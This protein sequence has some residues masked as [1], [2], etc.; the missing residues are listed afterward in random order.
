LRY[1]DSSALVPL[2]SK[3]AATEKMT[4]LYRADAAIATWWSSR[5]ECES[6]IAR[7]MR[8]GAIAEPEIAIA[9]GKL[10][11]L[12]REWEEVAPSEEL[13]EAARRLVR[14]RKLSAADALQLAAALVA[15]GGSPPQLDFVCLDQ[16]LTTAATAEGFRVITA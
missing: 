2:L 12:Y 11:S 16:R 1:W 13:R 3:Q 9:R 7:L 6:A 15:A 4:H 14:T 10:Q 8:D 5:V